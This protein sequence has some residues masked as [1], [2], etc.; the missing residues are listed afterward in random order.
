MF[1][2][3]KRRIG[4]ILAGTVAVW[5]AAANAGPA[6]SVGGGLG[7]VGPVNIPGGVTGTIQQLPSV[8]S[9]IGRA[10]DSV[11]DGLLPSMALT[12]DTAGRPIDQRM[13]DFSPGIKVVRGQLLAIEPTAS[14]LAI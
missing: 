14:D 13:L 4:L 6:I 1:P 10:V 8:T 3:K 7:A 5:S 2:G 9:G 12:V 11:D